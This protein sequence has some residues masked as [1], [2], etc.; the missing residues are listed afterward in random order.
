MENGLITARLS[1]EPS[2]P[3]MR[4][5]LSWRFKLCFIWYVFHI[6]SRHIILL[7]RNCVY[8]QVT[9]SL[10]GNIYILWQCIVSICPMCELIK[11]KKIFK[12]INRLIYVY[13]NN[14]HQGLLKHKRICSNIMSL[15]SNFECATSEPRSS[16]CRLNSIALHIH[17]WNLSS[18][19]L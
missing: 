15:F 4:T 12:E 1:S 6:F 17:T 19:S 9:D 7:F 10:G 13:D 8:D 5:S 14:H 18:F 2:L 3:I 16:S 11:N